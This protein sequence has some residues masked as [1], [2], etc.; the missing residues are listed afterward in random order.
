MTTKK[1]FEK[2]VKEIL[3]VNPINPPKFKN[4]MPSK[5]QLEKKHRLVRQ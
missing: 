3:L 1:T 5:D 4:K 2:A